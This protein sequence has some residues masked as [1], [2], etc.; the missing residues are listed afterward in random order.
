M[1]VPL[2]VPVMLFR[3]VI[4]VYGNSLNPQELLLWN[5]ALTSLASYFHLQTVKSTTGSN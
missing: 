3:D 2:T 5:G 4:S 1:L